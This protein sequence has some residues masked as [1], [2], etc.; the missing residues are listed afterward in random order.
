LKD[1]GFSYKEGKF[2]PA[3]FPEA[4]RMP[5]KEFDAATLRE[6]SLSELIEACGEGFKNLDRD[7][8]TGELFW[9]CN[10]YFEKEGEINSQMTEGKSPEE[11]VAN[12]WLTLNNK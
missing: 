11:A 9:L 2:Y 4:V 3:I 8:T 10:N 1:A 12:L 6:V 5:I 7:T